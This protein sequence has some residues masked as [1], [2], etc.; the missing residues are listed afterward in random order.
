MEVAILGAGPSGMMAAHAVRMLGGQVVIFDRDPDQTRRSSGVYFLHSACDLTL[1]PV[2]VRHR[3]T[4]AMGLTV[5]EVA[6][7]YSAKVY[8]PGNSPKTSVVSAL[9]TP[10]VVAYNAEEALAQ[11]W[12]AYGDRVQR[13][14]ISGLVDVL[15]LRDE[16]GLVVSTIPAPTL[17]PRVEY[18][19]VQCS[20]VVRQVER[21]KP[22]VEYN[23]EEGVSWY[24]RAS[25][26]GTETTEYGVGQRA[27]VGMGAVERVV[28]KV[29]GRGPLPPIE[30]LLLTGRYGAWDKWFLTDR[31]YQHVREWVQQRA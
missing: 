21:E 4:G 17:F 24:R 5:E 6:R 16:V 8:G 25:L 1:T 27:V 11:L 31:V 15:R 13:W 14:A 26:F 30:G 23:I 9:A 10:E 3:V 7:R 12:Q 28:T 20:V 29:V 22:W 18:A 2:T 19:S